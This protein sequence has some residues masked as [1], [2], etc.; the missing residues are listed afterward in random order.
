MLKSV[1]CVNNKECV[2]LQIPNQKCYKYVQSTQISRL[3]LHDANKQVIWQPVSVTLP[4]GT[5]HP[6]KYVAKKHSIIVTVEK[7]NVIILLT[8][9]KVSAKYSLSNSACHKTYIH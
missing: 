2:K 7:C 9:Y 4:L 8:G 5:C 6:R 1:I 3:C